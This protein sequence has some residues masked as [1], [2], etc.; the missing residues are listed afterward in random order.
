[1]SAIARSGLLLA[2][3][4]VIGLDCSS[5]QTDPGAG[6]GGAQTG[7]GGSMSGA[8]GAG[9][10]GNGVGGITVS[11]SGGTT[12]GGP[13]GAGTGGA[14][15]GTGGRTTT[16]SGGAPAGSGGATGGGG[17][18]AAVPSAGCGRGGRPANGEV[19]VTNDHI[20]DFPATYD[21]RTPMPLLIGLHAN[22]NPYT[23]IQGLTNGT[24]LA[25]GFIRAFPKSQ[26]QGW[27]LATDAANITTMYGDLLANYCVDTSRVF[28]T[29]H[30]SGAQMVVQM[31]C[32]SGGETRFKAV[33]PVA[34]SKYC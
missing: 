14:G 23:Q 12:P 11:G 27:V 5:A 34:A 13:G 28:L 4:L 10:G 15:T 22:A 21:G 7:S 8:G 3:L 31:L 29:G 2:L 1:M 9:T 19:T 25:T 20:Y 24:R 16:G 18:A 17:V 32:V 6:A 33:A 30:S 26:G